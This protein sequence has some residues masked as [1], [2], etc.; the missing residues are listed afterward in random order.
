MRPTHEPLPA[1]TPAEAADRLTRA[2]RNLIVFA[3]DH[4][5]HADAYRDRA[6]ECLKRAANLRKDSAA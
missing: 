1:E 5:T 2:A 4:E 3:E 6:R